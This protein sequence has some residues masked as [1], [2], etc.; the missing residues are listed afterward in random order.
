MLHASVRGCANTYVQAAS[1]AWPCVIGGVHVHCKATGSAATQL[2]PPRARSIKRPGIFRGRQ[3]MKMLLFPDPSEG[4]QTKSISAR[5]WNLASA[6]QQ[7]SGN[8]DRTPLP[9]LAA[10]SLVLQQFQASKK[11]N[12]CREPHVRR[13]ICGFDKYR[14]LCES[15][16]SPSSNR[17]VYNICQL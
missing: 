15:S 6:Q 14:S 9:R 8:S 12:C 3:E 16:Q 7:T 11:T 5:Q 13:L 17:R 10:K 2:I 4:T 1:E